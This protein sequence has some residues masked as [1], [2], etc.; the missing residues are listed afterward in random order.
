[1]QMHQSS[2]RDEDSEESGDS[3]QSPFKAQES[4]SKEPDESADESSLEPSDYDSAYA[5]S[6]KP[7]AR[8]LVSTSQL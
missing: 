3:T 5:E 2:S 8:Q 4:S 6:L 7:G 1:M